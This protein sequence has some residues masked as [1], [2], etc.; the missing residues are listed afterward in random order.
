MARLF[1]A[2]LPASLFAWTLFRCALRAPS[3]SIF[4]LFLF[5]SLPSLYSFLPLSLLSGTMI[6]I[7]FWTILYPFGPKTPMETFYAFL[8]HGCT[9]IFIWVSEGERGGGEIKREITKEIKRVLYPEPQPPRPPPFSPLFFLHLSL[10]HPTFAL[11]LS[12]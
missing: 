11:S 7:I 3:L 8:E 2:P 6:G 5:P 1:L 9:T 12:Q 4:S 10:F